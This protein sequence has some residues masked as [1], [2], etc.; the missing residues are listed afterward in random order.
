MNYEKLARE[1]EQTETD[2]VDSMISSAQK[3]IEA[4]TVGDGSDW[5]DQALCSALDPEL[6]DTYDRTAI[7]KTMAKK[8][9]EACGVSAEC[10]EYVLNKSS[11]FEGTMMWAGLTPKEIQRKRNIRLRAKLHR[12]R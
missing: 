5:R 11:G 4:R 10:L 8:V 2:T 9:C 12:S 3:T 1:L 7:E 6:L